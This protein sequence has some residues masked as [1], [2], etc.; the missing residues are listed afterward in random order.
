MTSGFPDA[1]AHVDGPYTHNTLVNTRLA[2]TNNLSKLLIYVHRA[3]LLLTTLILT[4]QPL[5]MADGC[6]VNYYS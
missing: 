6:S 5:P 1:I 2:A 4:K 3:T